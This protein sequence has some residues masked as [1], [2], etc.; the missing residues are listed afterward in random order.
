M[1]KVCIF[2]GRPVPHGQQPRGPNTTTWKDEY[3]LKWKQKVNQLF[4]TEHH[5]PKR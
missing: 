5:G 4:R 2:Q 3:D 1:L